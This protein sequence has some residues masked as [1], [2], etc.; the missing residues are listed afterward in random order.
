MASLMS[1]FDAETKEVAGYAGSAVLVPTLHSQSQF[2][3]QQQGVQGRVGASKAVTGSRS[4]RSGDSAV[5][6]GQSKKRTSFGFGS[7]CS[8]VRSPGPSASFVS[9]PVRVKS[10][11]SNGNSTTNSTS[12]STSASNSARA[13]RGA[14]ASTRTPT[15]AP[16]MS[17]ALSR[18][19]APSSTVSRSS[20]GG[21]R[22]NST[23]STSSTNTDTAPEHPQ[24][25]RSRLSLVDRAGAAFSRSS[26]R[27]LGGANPV[28]APEQPSSRSSS[29]S[30]GSGGNSGG[31]GSGGN[32]SGV[33]LLTPKAAEALAASAVLHE[34]KGDKGGDKGGG[35]DTQWDRTTRVWYPSAFQRASASAEEHL[36][37]AIRSIT[38]E[39]EKKTEGEEEKGEMG[40]GK[41]RAP[42]AHSN[43]P[44][45]YF[46]PVSMLNTPAPAPRPQPS[47]TR[48]R[49]SSLPS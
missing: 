6:V 9:P 27:S 28:A 4:E 20:L 7:G 35:R 44:A 36:A 18:A 31:S 39:G 29:R 30:R 46:S 34:V 38:E 24:Q 49:P 14:P 22:P 11:V 33:R 37:E 41:V 12:N 15:T 5:G 1:E 2:R 19:L 25:P 26:R 13:S 3:S 42:F 10:S 45:D 23:S 8:T 21:E 16:P 17:R 47:P 40:A 32:G 43:K 48:A